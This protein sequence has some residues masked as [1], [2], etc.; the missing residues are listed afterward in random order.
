MELGC[1]G[2]VNSWA[3]PGHGHRRPVI[4]DSPSE[5]LSGAS[6][7]YFSCFSTL[8][9]ILFCSFLYPIYFGMSFSPESVALNGLGAVLVFIVLANTYIMALAMP[10]TDLEQLSEY[11]LRSPHKAL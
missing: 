6:Y 8:N 5:Q 10:A 11:E 2:G 7:Y 4:P 1:R 9:R 3:R